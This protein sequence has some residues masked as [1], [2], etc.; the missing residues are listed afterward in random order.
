MEI[1][2]FEYRIVSISNIRPFPI[3]LDQFALIP[4]NFLD[5]ID[6]QRQLH[7]DKQEP[8]ITSCIEAIDC[9]L[10]AVTG[11]H[12]R[13]ATSG[14]WSHGTP[15]STLSIFS[16]FSGAEHSVNAGF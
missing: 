7:G 5:G 9:A 13:P 16:I 1:Q 2:H 12:K 6:R 10:P 8:M 15:T 14:V 3:R 11:T 4:E